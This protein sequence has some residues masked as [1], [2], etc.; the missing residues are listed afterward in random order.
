MTCNYFHAY[1]QLSGNPEVSVKCDIYE[2]YSHKCYVTVPSQEETDDEENILNWNKNVGEVEFK[3]KE[4]VKNYNKCP[5]YLVVLANGGI[6]GSYE[7]HAADSE[8]NAK[9]IQTN[10][11]R[12]ETG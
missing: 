1:D 6:F 8:E 10:L 11:G 3:A 5:D 4:Y 2:D 12:K 7:L 9:T